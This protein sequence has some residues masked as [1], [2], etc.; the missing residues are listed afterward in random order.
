MEI[1]AAM[2]IGIIG[3]ISSITFAYIG[4][5]NGL[6]KESTDSGKSSGALMSDVGYIK[7]GVDD[8][9]RKQETSE[10]R[11]YALVERV[12]GVEESAKQAHLRINELREEVGK[13]AANKV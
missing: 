5:R 13:D 6:K 9:K 10:T 4:Y 1:N 2:V 11:H 7:A 8:L 3:T 12:K